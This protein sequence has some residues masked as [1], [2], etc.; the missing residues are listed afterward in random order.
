MKVTLNKKRIINCSKEG[1]YIHRGRSTVKEPMQKKA[2]R[3]YR[4][5]NF[6]KKEKVSHSKGESNSKP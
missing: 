5:G 4:E 6:R 3:K 2:K 1:Q